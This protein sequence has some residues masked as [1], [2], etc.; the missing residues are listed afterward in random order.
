MEN[1]LPKIGGD[2]CAYCNKRSFTVK[3]CGRC[4][5]VKK[6]A[7]LDTGNCTRVGANLSTKISLQSSSCSLCKKSLLHLKKCTRYGI[8]IVTVS[9]KT[10]LNIRKP[11]WKLQNGCIRPASTLLADN[12]RIFQ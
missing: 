10:G 7:K 12:M 9:L 3:K 6:G 1:L 5:Q 11:V 4:T 8:A 2:N